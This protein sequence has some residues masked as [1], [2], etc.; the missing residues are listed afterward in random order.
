MGDPN[1][2]FI[3]FIGNLRKNDCIL[4]PCEKYK[5]MVYKP[6]I[7]GFNRLKFYHNGKT[8]SGLFPVFKAF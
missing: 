8:T 4:F 2:F 3:G 6:M 7:S 5:I 1:P